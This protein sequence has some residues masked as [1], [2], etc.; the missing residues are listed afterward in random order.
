MLTVITTSARAKR[1]HHSSFIIHHFIRGD[2]FARSAYMNMGMLHFL[3]QGY[4]GAS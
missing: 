1:I 4:P 2:T 3:Q